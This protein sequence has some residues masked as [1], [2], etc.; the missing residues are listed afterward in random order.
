MDSKGN[1]TPPL[2]TVAEAASVFCVCPK[3]IR[4]WIKGGLLTA[5][6]IGRVVRIPRSELERLTGGG[7]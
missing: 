5:S 3:T 2:V 7:Q 4:N 6:R 1:H